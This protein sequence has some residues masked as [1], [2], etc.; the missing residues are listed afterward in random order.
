MPSDSESYPDVSGGCFCADG[1]SL[2]VQTAVF[3]DKSLFF[4]LSAASVSAE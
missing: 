4:T 1:V 3:S 2:L